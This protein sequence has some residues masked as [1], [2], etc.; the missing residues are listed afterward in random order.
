MFLLPVADRVKRATQKHT[1]GTS[2]PLAPSGEVS[3]SPNSKA[4]QDLHMAI[5]E[6][7][8]E[9]HFLLGKLDPGQLPKHIANGL[10]DVHCAKAGPDV[11]SVLPALKPEHMQH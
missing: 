9:H 1:E 11:K 8:D 10:Q 2:A 4:G 7:G 3:R 6:C 5:Q